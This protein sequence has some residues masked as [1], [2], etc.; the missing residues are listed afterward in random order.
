M[1]GQ[2]SFGVTLAHVNPSLLSCW[3]AMVKQGEECSLFLKHSDGRITATLQCTTSSASSTSTP[4]AGELKKKKKKKKSKGNKKRRF[5]ALLA[6]HQRLVDEKGLPPSRL[7]KQHAAA[8]E[9]ASASQNAELRSLSSATNAT[10][11]RTPSVVWKYTLGKHTGNLRNF[12]GILARITQFLQTTP[13]QQLMTKRTS[14][15]TKHDTIAGSRSA[16]NCPV[17]NLSVN[18]ILMSEIFMNNEEQLLLL[19]W[20]TRDPYNTGPCMTCSCCSSLPFHVWCMCKWEIYIYVHTSTM[21]W[22]HTHQPHV[23]LTSEEIY[24]YMKQWFSLWSNPR[25]PEQRK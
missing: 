23:S 25:R 16:P 17:L 15:K 2:D 22:Y 21:H 7:M 8:S 12:K 4:P 13:K 24:C 5:E 6:F 1:S 11:H 14:R 18:S 10:S 20:S 9:S 3:E 19:L